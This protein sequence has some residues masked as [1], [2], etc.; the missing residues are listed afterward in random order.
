MRVILQ[1]VSEATVRVDQHITGQIGLGLLV[2]A[3]FEAQ[4]QR[5]DLEWMAQKI[6]NL[7]IFPDSEGRMNHSLIEAEGELL[8]VS[9]FTLY[10]STRKGNRPAWGKA[11]K[12]E[13][14]RPR[15]D[16][17]VCL[18]QQKFGKPIPTGVFGADMK[19]SL[20]NDGP[21]TLILDS[22]QPE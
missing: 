5:E 7:R 20:I 15:F 9:Q 21:V 19:I 17:F 11:A 13:I 16:E 8:A 10:A 14:S 22:R 2:L 6:I 4:D 18:L 12:G 3:C 1:R